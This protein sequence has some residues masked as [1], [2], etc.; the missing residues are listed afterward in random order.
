MAAR[1]VRWHSVAHPATAC[2][3]S[4]IGSRGAREE[5]AVAHH[6]AMDARAARIVRSI[7]IRPGE[8]RRAGSVAGLFA[9]LEIG[10]GLGEIGADTLVLRG[11]GV[12]RLPEVL[13]FLY[14]GLGIVGL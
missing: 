13:P 4:V 10:R 6:R 7:G 5:A 1:W 8:G 3:A 9:L 14:I 2:H 11:F 12:T